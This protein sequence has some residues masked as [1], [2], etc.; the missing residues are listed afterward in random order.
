MLKYFKPVLRRIYLEDFARDFL[1]N[2][3]RTRK[4]LSWHCQR[5]F[6]RVDRQIIQGYLD[7]HTLKKLHIGCG[8]NVLEGWLNS[9]FYPRSI[10]VFHLNAIKPFPF[11]D[12]EFDYV[13]SEHMIEHI[14]YA[15][16]S[17]LLAECFRVLKKNGKI[18]LSTPNLAFLIDLYKEEKSQ[19]QMDYCQ[20]LNSE[21]ATN[22]VVETTS[23]YLDTF[24]INNFVRD[25]GHEFIYD[26]KTLR[27]AME[28]AGFEN[29]SRCNIS[30]S[31]DK[32]LRNLENE[33]REPPGFL[34]LESII[35]EGTKLDSK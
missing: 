30:E 26:E 32:N 9:N 33:K 19:L 11:G 10:N 20:W 29:I 7:E 13:F 23:Y 1:Q 27:L 16:G 22:N 18:R 31:N 17:L 5:K 15:E 25:W 28:T 21:E 4:S 8:R 12:N 3:R 2:I 34:A 24:V 35:M 6:G 14:P